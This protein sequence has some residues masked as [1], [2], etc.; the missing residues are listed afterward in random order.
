[1]TGS[2][3]ITTLIQA[4]VSLPEDRYPIASR[5]RDLAE[6]AVKFIRGEMY[7]ESTGLLVRSWREGKGPVRSSI[8]F[9]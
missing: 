5:C 3:Q 6:N 9:E 2:R 4:S 8:G 7:D 1:M